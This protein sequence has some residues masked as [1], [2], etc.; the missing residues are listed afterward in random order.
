MRNTRCAEQASRSAQAASKRR[1]HGRNAAHPLCALA[2]QVVERAERTKRGALLH[3][4]VCACGFVHDVQ[5]LREGRAGAG[6]WT[7]RARAVGC[8][9]WRL[10]AVGACKRLRCT[11]RH[12]PQ[13]PRAQVTATRKPLEV[14]VRPPLLSGA[15][16]GGFSAASRPPHSLMQRLTSSARFAAKTCSQKCRRHCSPVVAHEQRASGGDVR[17]CAAHRTSKPSRRWRSRTSPGGKC[18]NCS[19]H[20]SRGLCKSIAFNKLHA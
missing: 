11:P 1:A 5:A 20:V 9:R 4:R 14:G 3:V 16:Q 13:S 6:L 10:P 18:A 7:R 8:R 12:A 2:Q 15:R 17:T 19:R